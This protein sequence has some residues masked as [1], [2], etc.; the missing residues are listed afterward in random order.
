MEEYSTKKKT[1]G[2]LIRKH[3]KSLKMSQTRYAELVG[4]GRFSTISAWESGYRE[5]PYRIIFRVLKELQL[6]NIE[7]VV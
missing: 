7:E 3:R 4:A 6:F 1:V 5:A 2:E